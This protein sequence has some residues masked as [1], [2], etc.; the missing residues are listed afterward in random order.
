MTFAAT[1]AVAVSAA[2][3]TAPPTLS[4][5]Y[6][7]AAPRNRRLHVRMVG[8]KNLVGT[9]PLPIR[10]SR[11]A[12][13]NGQ[14]SVAGPC[15][16]VGAYSA[17]ANAP[18]V[19][20]GGTVDISLQYAA[21]H[22]NQNNLFKATFACGAPTENAMQ[23]GNPGSLELTAAQCQPKAGSGNTAAYPPPA[24]TGRDA[25]EITCTLPTTG[26]PGMDLNTAVG[27]QCSISFQDQRDWGGC[28]DFALV[29]PQN[30]DPGTGG[31]GG[32]GGGVNPNPINGGGGN[33]GTPVTPTAPSPPATT[34]Y[35]QAFN[36]IVTSAPPNPSLGQFECC[37]LGAGDV[38]LRS[39]RATPAGASTIVLSGSITGNTCDQGLGFPSN[40]IGIQLNN[41]ALEGALGD[42]QFKSNALQGL[43]VSGVNVDL[44]Y[45]A[46]TLVLTM[47]DDFL[48][49]GGNPT[50]CD[51]E[52]PF[53]VNKKAVAPQVNGDPAGGTGGLSTAAIVILVLTIL[54]VVGAVG[55]VYSIN[56]QSGGGGSSGGGGAKPAA[57]PAAKP[58]VAMQA[59]APASGGRLKP[60]WSEARDDSGDVYYFNKRTGETTWEK[61]LVMA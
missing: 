17:G 18:Q 12:G 3:D 47:N 22:E 58:V 41:V 46:G 39:G 2:A 10:N 35:S 43:T 29:A 56:N 21:G 32:G 52:V 5:S 59:R 15:G 34:L 44:S 36:S 14:A 55:I 37:A 9:T 50:I 4:V 31:G 1:A 30:E 51:L 11:A 54:T 26:V 19:A 42:I 16:G 24:Q 25:K 8:D 23:V 28:V 20:S 53:A 7:R 13:A 57:K 27:K 60:D 6:D 40:S 45:I 61:H 49:S 33:A 48:S 38:T